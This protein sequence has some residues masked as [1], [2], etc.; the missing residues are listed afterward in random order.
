[1]PAGGLPIGAVIVKQHVADA[2]APGDHGST[3]AGNPLVCHAAT[4][5]MDIIS[6]P[7]F[8]AGPISGTS[9]FHPTARQDPCPLLH[10]AFAVQCIGLLWQLGLAHL[11]MS[12]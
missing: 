5:V 10:S 2:M 3:F 11:R 1:M 9:C 7:A 4:V 12:L 6:D 8:L